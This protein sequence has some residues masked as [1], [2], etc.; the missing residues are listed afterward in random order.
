MDKFGMDYYLGLDMGTNSVGWAV[1]NLD[2]DLMKYHN[3][4]MWGVRLFDEAN[5]AA[6]RRTFRSSRR[7]LA[8][9]KWRLN[10]LAQLFE[11]EISAVD[12]T[13]FL[14]LKDSALWM[15]DKNKS[16]NTEYCLF[17]DKNYTDVE[18]HKEFP[19]VYHLRMA[20]IKNEKQYDVRLVYL[21]L[22]N[23][24]K[25]RGH[26]LF[27]GRDMKAVTSFESVFNEMI[28]YLKDEMNIDLI[29]ENI[30]DFGEILKNK[31]LT[32]TRKKEKLATLCGIQKSEKQVKAILGLL[33][34]TTEE[35]SV[36]YNN[37]A[38]K[39]LEKSKISFSSASYEDDRANLDNALQ[40][41]TYLIDKLK[42][43]YDWSILEEILSGGEMDGQQ[44]L[45]VSKVATYEKHK[46]DLVVLKKVIKKN[47]PD[48]YKKFFPPTI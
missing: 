1:T 37:E 44:Y 42:A 34:G 25:H 27:E 16:I 36:V 47:C 2:Y 43:L 23:I 29:C 8:R 40:E 46:E 9:K 14:R 4:A 30:D 28:T 7:R 12:D 18:Y 3:K 39:E 22:H 5:Q 19:T 24:L 13:F 26:F 17:N 10:I 11:K 41:Q 45:S 20:L 33:S 15:E 31:Q 6:E 21:A 38:L 32:K 48:E 35:L